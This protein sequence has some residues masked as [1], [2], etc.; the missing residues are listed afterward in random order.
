MPKEVEQVRAP[1]PTSPPGPTPQ[2]LIDTCADVAALPLVE[3]EVAIGQKLWPLARAL[4]VPLA[5]VRR[6]MELQIAQAERERRQAAIAAAGPGTLE[7]AASD[8]VW[9]RYA[10][11]VEYALPPEVL[12]I[13]DG[14]QPRLQHVTG[15]RIGPLI[16]P[17]AEY[18]DGDVRL[19]GVDRW[20]REVDFTVPSPSLSNPRKLDRLMA[21]HGCRMDD[22]ATWARFALEILAAV[23]LRDRNPEPQDDLDLETL[24]AGLIGVAGAGGKGGWVRVPL[25]AVPDRH[26]RRRLAEAGL[27]RRDPQGRFTYPAPGGR[28]VLMLRLRPYGGEDAEQGVAG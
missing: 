1:A 23:D 18:P 14:G 19:R 2:D 25:E 21:E 28:R 20:G 6:I 15:G 26:T 27:L 11:G 16:Y 7:R 8:A 5:Q 10:K 17:T 22:A 12:A 4:H 24:V 13:E 3:R 9:V